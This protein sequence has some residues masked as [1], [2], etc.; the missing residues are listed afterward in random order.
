M[1]LIFLRGCDEAGA[2][3]VGTD[4]WPGKR[5]RSLPSP[6]ASGGS[7][8]STSY[9]QNPLAAG[10]KKRNHGLLGHGGVGKGVSKDTGSITGTVTHI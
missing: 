6:L 3:R 8:S 10:R 9:H 5:S 4:C 1:V 2:G 7:P